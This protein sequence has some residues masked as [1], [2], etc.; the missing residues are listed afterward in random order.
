MTAEQ[1]QADAMLRATIEAGPDDRTA[2]LVWADALI[3]AGDDDRAEFVQVQCDQE[4]FAAHKGEEWDAARRYWR[5]RCEALLRAH[6]H[7]WRRGGACRTCGGRGKR[8]AGGHHYGDR[9]YEPCRKCDGTGDAVGLLRRVRPYHPDYGHAGPEQWAHPVRWRRGLPDAVECTLG[10]VLERGRQLC[11]DCFATGGRVP[12]GRCDNGTIYRP[13]QPT[14]WARA[15]ATHHPSV[16]RFVLTDREPRSFGAGEWQW[17][18]GGLRDQ[19]GAWELP[20]PVFDGLSRDRDR[21][22]YAFQQPRRSYPTRAV[23]LDEMAVA[24]MKVVRG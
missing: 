19:F 15:V 1:V 4:Q 20:E 11:V 5:D 13:W 12:C 10:E 9:E 3:E 7:E 18:R 6:E 17:L 16:T 8:L 22:V 24:V 2:A 23:A 14:A 21:A